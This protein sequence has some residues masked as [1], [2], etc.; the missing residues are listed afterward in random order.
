MNK[1]TRCFANPS[2]D[3]SASDYILTKKQT[4][5]YNDILKQHPNN[6]IKHNGVNYN[7]LK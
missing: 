5:I 6:F 4:T 1:G 2:D 3:N 7:E